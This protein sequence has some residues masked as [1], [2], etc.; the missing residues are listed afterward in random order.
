MEAAGVHSYAVDVRWDGNRGTGTSGYAGYDRRFRVSV[1]GKADL[2]GSADPAFRGDPRLY[3]PE[4]LLLAAV[5]SCHMLFYLSL[6]ARSGI[7]VVAYADAAAGTMALRPDGGGAF[8]EIVL[9]P[10][11]VVSVT[12]DREAAFALHERAGELCFIANSCRFP[13]RHQAEV[14][15][16]EAAHPGAGARPLG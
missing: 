5:A 2:A 9:R 15:A 10:R 3:N 4:E 12:S 16:E 1:T 6:C 11:V 7:T 13:I 14:R 8:A